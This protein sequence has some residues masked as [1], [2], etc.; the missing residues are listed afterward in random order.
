MIVTNGPNT[1]AIKVIDCKDK[2][3]LLGLLRILR[4]LINQNLNRRGII[5][6]YINTINGLRTV[7]AARS[8]E[9]FVVSVVSIDTVGCYSSNSRREKLAFQIKHF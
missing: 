5:D 4:L 7:A 1:T 2:Q 6:C 9:C 8:I 3:P